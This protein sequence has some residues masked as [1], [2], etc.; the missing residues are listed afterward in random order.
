ME[1]KEGSQESE[2]GSQENG[3]GR[4]GDRA[5]GRDGDEKNFRE[6]SDFG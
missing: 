6:P 4:G 3:D 5:T 1:R 2:D